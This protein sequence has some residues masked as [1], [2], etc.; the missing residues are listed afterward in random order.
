MV[1]HDAEQHVREAVD[2]VRHQPI[3]GGQVG[4]K[5][6]VRPEGQRHAVEEEELSLL[7]GG[8]RAHPSGAG[9]LTMA[10]AMSRMRVRD[11]MAVCWIIENA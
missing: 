8:A 11:C 5:C 1:A 7:P 2:G 3:R 10:E 6:E 4:R 9:G